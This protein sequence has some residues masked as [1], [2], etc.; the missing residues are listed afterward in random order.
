MIKTF[1]FVEDGSVDLDELKS[2]VG[3]DVL[4]LSYRQG[5]TPPAI[6]QPREPVLRREV[7]IKDRLLDLM[8][9]FDEMGFAPTTVCDD[10]EGVAVKWKEQVVNEIERLEV[11]INTL[12]HEAKRNADEAIIQKNRADMLKEDNAG[13]Q[14]ELKKTVKDVAERIKMAFYYEF[15]E[16]IPSTMADKIDELVKEICGDE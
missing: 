13:L 5:A 1:I 14:E 9:E 3:D 12:W 16:L 15:D 4:V 11:K 10:A 6:Q 2:S 7:N 8:I